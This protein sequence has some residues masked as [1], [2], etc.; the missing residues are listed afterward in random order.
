MC[1]VPTNAAPDM[2][3]LGGKARM[4]T[5]TITDSGSSGTGGDDNKGNNVQAENLLL[6]VSVI[7]P[8]A[9]F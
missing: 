5:S 6:E 8:V 7:E 9:A 1:G 4:V 3:G 2:T